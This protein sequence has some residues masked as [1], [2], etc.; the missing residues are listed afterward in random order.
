MQILLGYIFTY[1]YLFIVLVGTNL[2]QKI[3]K[4]DKEIS[5]KII[6]ILVGLSWFI[7]VYY[8]NTSWH[9]IIPPFTFI[10]I[11]Y[12]SYKKRIF[13]SMERDNKDSK[14]TIYY[15]LSFTILASL[16]V[17]NKEFLPYY[18][19]GVLSM[20]IGDGL[21]PFIGK[22]SIDK[23][24]KSDKTYAGFL[25]IFT[26]TFLIMLMF[27]N[28]YLLNY[29]FIKLWVLSLISSLLELFGGKYDNLTLPLG[30]ALITFFARS[31]PL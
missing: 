20:A 26:C 1:S 22:L 23:I 5:R 24:G 12:I 16:T 8:F 4:F 18:G 13:S 31:I 10:I 21:A 2:V 25:T 29:G 7:M 9:L 3:F 15:A 14:G 11:N 19:M 30:I 17:L 6:H 27:S 28:Y